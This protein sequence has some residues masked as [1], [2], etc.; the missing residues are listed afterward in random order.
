MK[1]TQDAD[2]MAQV[3]YVLENMPANQPWDSSRRLYLY[4]L[5]GIPE[6]VI[7]QATRQLLLESEWR[8]SPAQIHKRCQEILDERTRRER[9]RRWLDNHPEWRE[10]LQQAREERGPQCGPEET[11]RRLRALRRGVLALSSKALP[12]GPTEEVEPDA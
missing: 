9:V 3:E 6:D 1:K 7:L 2:K 4:V 10:L 8:P 11:T 12:P 5:E